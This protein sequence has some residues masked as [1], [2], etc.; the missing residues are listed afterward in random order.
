MLPVS[1]V[2]LLLDADEFDS[3]VSG[4]AD[5][6]IARVDAHYSYACGH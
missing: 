4:V 6:A 1:A 3:E 2:S 5:R